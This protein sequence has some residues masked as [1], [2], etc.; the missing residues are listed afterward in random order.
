M[1]ILHKMHRFPPTAQVSYTEQKSYEQ[2]A[3]DSDCYYGTGPDQLRKPILPCDSAWDPRLGP[4]HCARCSED[5]RARSSAATEEN[6]QDTN[7][8]DA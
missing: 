7:V 4:S 3:A 1:G 6:E 5:D 8:V 2:A